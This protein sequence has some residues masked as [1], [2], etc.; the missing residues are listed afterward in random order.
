MEGE[1]KPIVI[2]DETR[3]DFVFHHVGLAVELG[4][5]VSNLNWL[6]VFVLSLIGDF[7][8]LRLP[9]PGT[10]DIH[11]SELK[12][13]GVPDCFDLVERIKTVGLGDSLVNEQASFSGDETYPPTGGRY[14]EQE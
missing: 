7:V 1:Q 4:A 11:C 6:T 14:R 3:I 2:V 10:R 12:V 5:Q 8:G 13:E 9:L